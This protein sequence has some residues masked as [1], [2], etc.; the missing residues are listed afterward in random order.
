MGEEHC[1]RIDG[2]LADG[3]EQFQAIK[4]EMSAQNEVLHT[5]CINMATTRG[6]MARMAD[7]M[8]VPIRRDEEEAR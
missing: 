6:T 2:L 8:N 5:I 1:R 4:K 3:R 7:K